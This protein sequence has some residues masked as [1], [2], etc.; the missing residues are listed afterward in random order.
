M[1]RR[2][3]VEVSSWLIE[4]QE[5]T[6]VIRTLP[7]HISF[8]RWLLQTRQLIRARTRLPFTGLRAFPPD[9]VQPHTPFSYP[10]TYTEGTSFF[11]V[12]G[13]MEETEGTDPASEVV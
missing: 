5:L 12:W 4:I 2:R 13:E 11:D 9:S 10:S 3:G 7:A 6:N 1:Y 8:F